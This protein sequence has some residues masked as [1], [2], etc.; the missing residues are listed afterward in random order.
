LF[1]GVA[2][3]SSVFYFVTKINM[4]LELAMSNMIRKSTIL[5]LPVVQRWEIWPSDS[6]ALW[7]SLMIRSL[8]GYLR[9]QVW[10]K[11]QK[12]NGTFNS[13]CIWT[14]KDRRFI[15]FQTTVK[16]VWKL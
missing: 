11:Q 4:P 5:K 13:P 14:E 9:P 3:F 2:K 12:S 6:C 15:Q 7:N 10:S 16:N 1:G 8:G